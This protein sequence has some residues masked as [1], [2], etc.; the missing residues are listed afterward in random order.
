MLRLG[1]IVYY[2][3]SLLNTA[4]N[5]SGLGTIIKYFWDR[6]GHK[7]AFRLDNGKRWRS[8]DTRIC[9]D[10]HIYSQLPWSGSAQLY[11]SS[12]HSDMSKFCRANP[13]N[14]LLFRQSLKA[15]LEG[16]WRNVHPH[17]YHCHVTIVPRENGLSVHPKLWHSDPKRRSFVTMQQNDPL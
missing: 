16:S 2:C 12:R 17:Y 14:G 10:M 8:T 15:C 3:I 4:S 13:R 9:P 6:H 11:N 5:M 7:N 1:T